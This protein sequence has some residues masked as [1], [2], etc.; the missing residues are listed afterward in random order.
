VKEN[1]KKSHT[2]FIGL[3]VLIVMSRAT[4]GHGSFQFEKEPFDPSRVFSVEQLQDDCR[5]LRTALEE[6]HGGLYYYSSKDEMD[7]LFDSI[8][9]RLDSPMSE[10]EFY[11]LLT[12]MVAGINDGHTGVLYSREFDEYLSAEPILMPFSLRFIEGRTYIYRNYCQDKDFIVGGEILSINEQPISEILERMLEYIPSDGHIRSSKYFRLQNPVNFGRMYFLLYGKTTS[13]KLGYKSPLDSTDKGILVAGLDVD[14]MKRIIEERYPA[15]EKTHPPIELGY[16][17]NVAVLTIRTFADGP[18]RL[19]GLS[20]PAFLKRTMEELSEK[21]IE[22]LI[23][24]LR[25]NGGGADMNG[26]LLFSYLIDRPYMYYKYLEVSRNEL[27][28]LEHSDSPDLNRML[29]SRTEKNE[30]GKHNLLLHPNLGEQKPMQP[31]FDGQVYV[32]INGGSFSASGETTS[33]M[34]FYKRAVFIGEECGA[35]YYGNTSGIMPTLTLPQT[36][37][38]IRIPMVRYV[39]D[40]SGY[41]H[42]DRGIIPDFPFSRKIGD[43][44]N[45]SDTELEFVLDLINKKKKED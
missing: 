41:D 36:R 4:G 14:E 3:F 2:F 42:P 19:A 16:K 37:I 31:I 15:A 5:L 11:R 43:L 28:F 39:M 26:K 8:F 45:G 32:L 23:I 10:A 20:F 7:S 6:A 30:R 1:M 13:F 18:Y 22:H 38:R 44:L 34:H 40:V 33:L 27:S 9:G 29:K 24:D 21:E 25:D 12:L 35:G 17:G